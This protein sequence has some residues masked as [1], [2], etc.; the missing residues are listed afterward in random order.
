MYNKI[1]RINLRWKTVNPKDVTSDKSDQQ[2]RVTI[3]QKSIYSTYQTMELLH[4]SKDLHQNHFIQIFNK[5]N[6]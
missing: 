4:T 1:N 5:P 2:L 3:V 6:I